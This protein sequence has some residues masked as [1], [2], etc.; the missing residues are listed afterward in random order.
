MNL[1]SLADAI[2]DMSKEQLDFLMQV[3]AIFDRDGDGKISQEEL[4]QVGAPASSGGGFS[5]PN[6]VSML[7][8]SQSLRCERGAPK[9]AL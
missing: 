8:G 4:D 5:V 7:A 2:E 9:E 1:D 6:W 3:F